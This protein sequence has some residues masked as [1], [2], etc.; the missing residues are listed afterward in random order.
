MQQSLSPSLPICLFRLPFC[1]SHYLSL[2]LT[3]CPSSSHL[4][5]FLSV[6]LSICLP[7]SPFVSFSISH[8][9]CLSFRVS[10]KDNWYSVFSC[11]TFSQDIVSLFTF[12]QAFSSIICQILGR[13]HLP[14]SA[15]IS[16][17]ALLVEQT[18][19]MC[20]TKRTRSKRWKKSLEGYYT[21]THEFREEDHKKGSDQ[22]INALHVSTSGVTD[23]P[24]EQNPL[25]HLKNK[26]IPLNDSFLITCDCCANLWQMMLLNSLLTDQQVYSFGCLHFQTQLH[27]KC[28]V[29]SGLWVTSVAQ[30]SIS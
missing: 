15:G 16:H 12:T 1:P 6:T 2:S 24:D 25:K 11:L 9:L 18:Q 3:V 14:D 28:S 10:F 23:G 27:F 4:L 5:L 30:S 29:P 7:L 13:L 19:L 22:I 20:S 26:T 17:N 8:F 21:L